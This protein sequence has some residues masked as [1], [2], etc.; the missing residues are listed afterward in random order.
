MILQIIRRA[1][2]AGVVLL[3]A[4]IATLSLYAHYRAAR[5]IDD[6]QLMAGLRC[7]NVVQAIH[8]YIDRLEDPAALLDANK[9]TLWS[10]RLGGIS[11]SDPLAALEATAA[12]KHVHWPLIL[13]AAIPVL[14]TLIL[15]RVF[16]SWICPAYLLLELTGKLRKFLRLAEINPAEVKFSPRNK[17]IVLLAGLALAAFFSAPLFALVYPPAVLSRTIH[18]W[19]FGTTLTGMVL[20]LGV[21]VLFEMFVSPRWWCR[22]VCPGGALYG[23]L[24]WLRPVR[25]KLRTDQCTACAECHPVCEEGLDPTTQSASIECDNCGVCIRHC[26]TKALH[27]GIGLPEPARDRPLT[28]APHSLTATSVLLAGLLLLLTPGEARGHHILGLPHYSY[29]ENYP[30]RPT[31]EYPAKTGPYDVLLTSY[32]G[33]PEPGEPANLAFYI[34]DQKAG[35]VYSEPITVRVLQTHTFGDSTVIMEPTTRGSFDNEYKFHVTLPM[36]GEYIVELSMMVEGRT[37]VIPFLMIAGEPTATASTAVAGG[38]A[39]LAA[40]VVIR[41]VQ[42]KRQRR[43]AGGSPSGGEFVG[44][45]TT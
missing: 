34:K 4:A 41:A 36:D 11:I 1:V 18:A 6:E 24:G 25:V 2:Q 20:L 14:L 5:V 40:F 35:R 27:F 15:G 42:K 13:S 12:S 31:L 17:Y 45:G 44:A 28:T 32:P 39:L 29:K 38:L 21:I 22:S 30:Q 43:A 19:V 9:G 7:E 10:M 37:E 3:L 16:C 8:P 33:V 23:W 26:P